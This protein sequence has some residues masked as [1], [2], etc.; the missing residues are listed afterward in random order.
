MLPFFPQGE[1]RVPHASGAYIGFCVTAHAAGE[2]RTFEF[3]K[4]SLR[5]RK[6]GTQECRAGFSRSFRAEA[7]MVCAFDGTLCLLL[8]PESVTAGLLA[9]SIG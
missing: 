3:D 5:K 4:S 6:R 9:A 2:Y 7:E 8:R 1:S